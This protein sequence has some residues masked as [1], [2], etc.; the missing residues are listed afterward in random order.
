MMNN[1]IWVK[2]KDMSV[3]EVAAVWERHWTQLNGGPHAK[4]S[5]L[6][7]KPIS[8]PGDF[9]IYW[10]DDPLAT[11]DDRIDH[12]FPGCGLYQITQSLP[13]DR[14]TSDRLAAEAM[15]ALV[16]SGGKWMT[17]RVLLM[18]WSVVSSTTKSRSLQVEE[19]FHDTNLSAFN[20]R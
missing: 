18:E 19:P 20:E 3:G 16:W 9:Q 10:W 2:I 11:T 15:L 14:K 6:V 17:K 12:V 13:W 4:C 1:P 5:G 7:Q 8:G